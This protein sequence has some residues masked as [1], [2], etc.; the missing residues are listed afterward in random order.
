MKPPLRRIGGLLVMAV[1]GCGDPTAPEEVLVLE[2]AAHT[3]ECAGPSSQ[4]CLLVRESGEEEWTYFY[5][6]I[7]GFAYEE[8]YRYTVRVPRRR[9]SDPPAD[10]SAFSYRLLEIISR[11][12]G[13]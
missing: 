9:V 7:E 12:A 10:G 2:I 4:R 6:A 5:D 11:E 1:A 13:P 3:A 8:G